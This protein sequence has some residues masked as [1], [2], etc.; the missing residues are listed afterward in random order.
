LKITIPKIYPI[1]DT[2]ISGLSH[3]EQVR[4]LVSGGASLIQ[5]RDKSAPAG[6][7]YRAAAEA[8]DHAHQ[9][10]A[11]III[12]DRADIALAAGADGVHLG[13]DDLSPVHARELL[14]PDAIIGFSTHSVEQAQK[15]LELPINYLAIGPI[16]VTSTKT[17]VAPA[18]GLGGLGAVRNLILNFPLVAIG[19]IDRSNAASVFE[20][21]ADSVAVISDLV[22]EPSNIADRVREL[23]QI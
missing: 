7:F 15:A 18:V 12:N 17:D 20:A 23:F 4:R 22:S 13:Q 11:K 8:I 3:L 9:Q 19:G 21:G 1:T 16:F 10:G 5:L 6:E 2:A 14:G